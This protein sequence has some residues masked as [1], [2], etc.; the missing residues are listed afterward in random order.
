MILQFFWE[1]CFKLK[2]RYR[3]CFFWSFENL[4]DFF[5]VY[6]C[7]SN[8]FILCQ[9]TGISFSGFR[10]PQQKRTKQRS[11]IACMDERFWPDTGLRLG[12]WSVFRSD[13][14][15]K[16]EFSRQASQWHAGFQ[17]PKVFLNENIFCPTPAK[18][19]FWDISIFCNLGRFIFLWFPRYFLLVCVWYWL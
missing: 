7:W 10:I 2:L 5:S 18:I 12:W 16:L 6:F 4:I 11:S 1:N 19:F 14:E 17:R 9:I 13:R 8:Y 15:E 3:R